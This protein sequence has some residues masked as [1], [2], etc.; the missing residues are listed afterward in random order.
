MSVDTLIEAAV[1]APARWVMSAR[2][3]AR[4]AQARREMEVAAQHLDRAGQE[5]DQIRLNAELRACTRGA[6]W[7]DSPAGRQHTEVQGELRTQALALRAWAMPDV[8][9]LR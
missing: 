3:R 4:L 9:R 8:S 2:D 5:L 1:R 7:G 6:D